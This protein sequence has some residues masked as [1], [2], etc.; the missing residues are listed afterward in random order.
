MRDRARHREWCDR[1]LCDNATHMS[2]PVRL[3]AGGC[4]WPPNRPV[5]AYLAE[6]S[7][8][9]AT[10]HPALT[11]RVGRG[12]SI[13]IPIQVARQLVQQLAELLDQAEAPD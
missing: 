10:T 8:L 6:S 1:D 13:M 7:G 11:V 4:L 5:T 2:T 9:A 12:A 3:D